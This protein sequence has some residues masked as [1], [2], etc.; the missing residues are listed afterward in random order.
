MHDENAQ[1]FLGSENCHPNYHLASQLGHEKMSDGL[2]NQEWRDFMR[3][4]NMGIV[5]LH[6]DRRR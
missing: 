3:A 2:N 6:R 5:A 1:P 4:R